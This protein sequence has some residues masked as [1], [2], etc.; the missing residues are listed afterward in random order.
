[1]V[2]FES[3]RVKPRTVVSILARLP[4]FRTGP[5]T[6]SVGV[7]V[8]NLFDARYAYNF[9][10]PFSGTHFGAPRT[11]AAAFRLEF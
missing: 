1:M 9:G 8:L 7:Q 6:G 3:G 10:N 4:L 11:A 2:D 5:A